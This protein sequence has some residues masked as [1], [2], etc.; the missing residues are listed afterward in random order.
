MDLL[1]HTPNG[2]VSAIASSDGWQE[3]PVAG[4]AVDFVRAYDLDNE[5]DAALEVLALA[6]GV[7]RFYRLNDDF[8]WAPIDVET[9]A[10]ELGVADIQPVDFDHE[11]DIDLLVVGEFGARLWRNDGAWVAEEALKGAYVDASQTASMPTGGNFQWALTEDF[12]G[13]NDVDLLMGGLGSFYLA[14][15]LRAGHFVNASGRFPQGTRFASRPVLADVNGDGRCDIVY[16]GGRAGVALQNRDLSFGEVTPLAGLGAGTTAVDLDLDGSL[17]L[18]S[19]AMA[20]LAVGTPV[21]VTVTLQGVSP[22][23]VAQCLL[24]ANADG[25]LDIARAAAR[26]VE[27]F[28][29][30]GER[31]NSIPIVVRGNKSNKRGMG[32]IV[33]VRVG[34]TYRRIYYRGETVLVG[35]GEAESIDILRITYPNGSKLSRLDVPLDSSELID[36]P[37]AALGEFAEPENLMGSC[38][39]LYTWNGETY[40]FITDVLGITPLGLPMAPGMMV[41]PDHDEFVL[42][43]GEQLQEHDGIYKVQF[44]EELR[45]VTYLDRAR[46]DVVDHPIGTEVYP[47]ELFK[48]PPFP[49]EH[50]HTVTA[51][52]AL[53]KA[54]GSDGEDWTAQLAEQDE[55]HAIPFTKQ[56]PQYQGLAKPWFLELEFD[57]E[58]IAKA[59]KLRLVMTGWFFWSDASANMAAAGAPGVDF[60][61]PMILVPDGAGGWRETGPPIG[62]PAGKTKTMVIDLAGLGLEDTPRIRLFCSLQLFWDRIVLATDDDAAERRITS[63]EPQSAVLRR[64][65]FSAPIPT[66]NPG[67]PERFE[68]D[69]LASEPRWNPHPGNYTKLGDCLPLLDAVDDMY[70]IMGTGEALEVHFDASAVPP[71]APGYRRDFLLYL[72]GW[73]KDRDHNTLEALEVEPLPFHGMSGYPYG[74]DEHFPSSEQ[75]LDWRAEWNTRAAEDWIEVLA[76]DSMAGD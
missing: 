57:P 65:G 38:P 66:D 60:I 30:T 14:D 46:L 53:V 51:P 43:K 64:R 13:D 48:F 9:P 56:L 73:A 37:S 72:D 67:L 32:A 36:D 63:I 7:L 69:R 3:L 44:T 23:S 47:N 29:A 50:L 34:S 31:G 49:E 54:T 58:A 2:I 62:F 52:S 4:G 22:N 27:L 12:D 6:N 17:D 55:V 20:V 39:F 1:A 33:E 28:S 59:D 26:G 35:V 21:Q 68:W 75:H 74:A 61:P 71:L 70:V 42:I 11:G 10:L 16:L 76:N 19:K 41:P 25:A 18:V 8:A 40:E 15:S 24:D 45:E 5:P